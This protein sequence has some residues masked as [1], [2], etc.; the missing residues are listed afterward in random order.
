M[1]T[2]LNQSELRKAL[3]LS[4]H[5]Q[6]EECDR[7]FQQARNNEND[8]TVSFGKNISREICF[9]K[10]GKKVARAKLLFLNSFISC[11]RRSY[12]TFESS[13]ICTPVRCKQRKFEE[14]HLKVSFGARRSHGRTSRQTFSQSHLLHFRMSDVVIRGIVRRNHSTV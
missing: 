13:G 2:C 7:I 5:M 4:L 6:L 12:A 8:I 10:S 11:R 1:A 14:G 3:R 9:L